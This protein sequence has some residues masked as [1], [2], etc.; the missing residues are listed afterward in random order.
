MS[1]K[2]AVITGASRGIGLALARML[3]AD[4]VDLC[5]C[6]RSGEAMREAAAMLPKN[7]RVISQACDV[8]D[9]AAVTELFARCR[10]ELGPIDWLVNNAA[11][12]RS[13]PLGQITEQQWDEVLGINL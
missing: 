1:R 4:G 2:I 8:S 13:T 3:A 5:L 7:G 11:I 12:A 6:A 10:R 9:A